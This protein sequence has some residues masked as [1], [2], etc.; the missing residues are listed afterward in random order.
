MDEMME[1]SI[2]VTEEA[3]AKKGNKGIKGFFS[4]IDDLVVYFVIF[5]LVMSF[6]FRPVI[7]NGTSML[8][9]LYNDDV[10]ILRSI[11]YTPDYGDIIVVSRED[12]PD[13]PLV[14]R[15]IALG[16]DTVYIDVNTH[17][18]YVNGNPL[19]EDYVF[20]DPN[21]DISETYGKIEYPYTVPYDCVF[22]MG[23]NRLNSTDS[24]DVGA[25]ENG[26]ILG[27]AILR[28]YRNTDKYGGSMFDY[29]G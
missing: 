21:Y 22:V 14:K 5:I 26:Q 1:S 2:T 3:D 19:K 29:L 18:V 20:I 11:L 4:W 28:I 25:I 24:T 7:V 27:K 6:V 17:T 10:L 9:T 16:G 15:V 13:R 23:D 8:H 12:H